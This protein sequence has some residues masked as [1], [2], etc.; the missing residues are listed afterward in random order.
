VATRSLIVSALS[1]VCP[2]A[3]RCDSLPQAA[4]NP[5]TQILGI[6]P[7]M[8][9][10]QAHH[11]LARLGKRIEL[12]GEDEAE[13][14]SQTGLEREVWRLEDRRFAWL[15]VTLD[16]RHR[17][18]ALQASV[19]PQGPGLR[20][21][22]IGDPGQG[23]RLGYTIWEWQVAARQGRPALRVTARGADSVY[24]ASVALAAMD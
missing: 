20:Y 7:G 17:V 12:A 16:A 3:A 18:R 24:A 9:E 15:Q 8:G 19:R 11:V 6:V 4:P 21:A 13:R 14:A 23:R 22:E 1:L 2:S 10:E 5:L